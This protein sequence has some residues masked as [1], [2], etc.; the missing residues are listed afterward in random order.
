MATQ[1]YLKSA[2]GARLVVM[3]AVTGLFSCA[4]GGWM[5]NYV[6]R[7]PEVMRGIGIQD[8]ETGKIV[9]VSKMCAN[10][11]RWQTANS[12][13]A[14]AMPLLFPAIMMWSI[15]RVGLMPKKVIPLELLKIT[16]L[17]IQLSFA[18]PCSMACYPQF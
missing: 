4:V 9:G 10:S 15:E 1:P 14:M 17:A 8:P 7:A 13:V 12:R 3:N 18:V 5:N 16:L 2:V 11:A 6:I